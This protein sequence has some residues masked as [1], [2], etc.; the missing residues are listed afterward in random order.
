MADRIGSI[1]V[2]LQRSAGVAVLQIRDQGPG[3]PE[4]ILSRVFEAFFTTKGDAGTGLGLSICKEIIEIEHA[5][6][7]AL[8]NHPEGGL[9]VEIRLPTQ[10][11]TER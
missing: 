9:L 10:Q 5:G 6:K 8:R 2:S 1:E 7:F 3:I 11:E 4:E